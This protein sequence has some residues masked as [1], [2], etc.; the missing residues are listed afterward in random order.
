MCSR[1]GISEQERELRSLPADSG[2]KKL[3]EK[4]LEALF[5]GGFAWDQQT[6]EGT[7]LPITSGSLGSGARGL[8][9]GELALDGMARNLFRITESKDLTDIVG[10]PATPRF[11]V[12]IVHP[13]QVDSAQVEAW[14]SLWAREKLAA[15]VRSMEARVCS[16]RG[17]SSSSKAHLSFRSA[18]VA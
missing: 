15:L 11:P 16:P 5:T 10:E 3:A 4:A 2:K 9:W 17:R 6:F 14:S 1:L 18:G 7:V 8:V 13:A 12:V